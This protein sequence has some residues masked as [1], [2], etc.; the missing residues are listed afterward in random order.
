MVLLVVGAGCPA[1]LARTP[2]V[3]AASVAVVALAVARGEQAT[4]VSAAAGLLVKT[5][6]LETVVMA[7][8]VAVV[9][10]RVVRVSK[11]LAALLQC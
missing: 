2:A 11:A 1:R 5:L 4:A 3:T 7:A 10:A 6:L 9:A 8:S